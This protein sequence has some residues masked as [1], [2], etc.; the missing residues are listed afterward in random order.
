MG[1][2]GGSA[3]DPGLPT[4][5]GLPYI[6]TLSP[7]RRCLSEQELCRGALIVATAASVGVPHAQRSMRNRTPP[8][9]LIRLPG[10]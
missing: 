2:D 3:R 8:A 6:Q 10:H 9:Q 1:W 4:T 7:S 5:A